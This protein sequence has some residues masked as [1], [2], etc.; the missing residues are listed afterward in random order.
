M[1]KLVFL[2]FPTMPDFL[3]YQQI[4]LIHVSLDLYF[5]TRISLGVSSP[6]L[7]IMTH[8][9]IRHNT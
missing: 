3:T 4:G 7:E 2:N 1:R 6:T 9:R 5:L 8:G